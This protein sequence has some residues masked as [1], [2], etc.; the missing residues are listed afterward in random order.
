MNSNIRDI[1]EYKYVYCVIDRTYFASVEIYADFY[2]VHRIFIYADEGQI[3]I[4]IISLIEYIWK[5]WN[6]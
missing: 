4:V 6:I 5:Y 2:C 3:M 1:R